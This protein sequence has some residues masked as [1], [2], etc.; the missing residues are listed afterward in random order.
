MNSQGG[1]VGKG[2]SGGLNVKLFNVSVLLENIQWRS[3]L[4]RYS[5]EQL[6]HTPLFRVGL[7]AYTFLCLKCNCLLVKITKWHC[8]C[9]P[10]IFV[11]RH[12]GSRMFLDTQSIDTKPIYYKYQSICRNCKHLSE[13]SRSPL[14]PICKHYLKSYQDRK[15][16]NVFCAEFS[17][18]IFALLVWNMKMENSYLL[19][20][21]SKAW[22][23]WYR[24]GKKLGQ[25]W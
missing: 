19:W 9:L 17:V 4:R 12:S 14:T 18:Y 16:P 25:L 22:V 23:L 10:H 11:K 21:N 1:Q 7:Y 6:V 3:S 8:V 2:G 20:K 5:T 13:T 15:S 24:Q